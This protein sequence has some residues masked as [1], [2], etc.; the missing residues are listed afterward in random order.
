MAGATAGGGVAKPQRKDKAHGV[1]KLTA[2]ALTTLRQ[3]FLV[4]ALAAS[5]LTRAATA[6]AAQV[7]E[8]RKALQDRGLDTKV[9]RLTWRWRARVVA[10]RSCASDA[11]AHARGEQGLK[12][13]LVA[14]MNEALAAEAKEARGRAATRIAARCG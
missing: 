4:A 13:A 9:R 14:R 6:T 3:R 1:E 7:P 11:D 10:P 8:L 5:A 2:R 12:S